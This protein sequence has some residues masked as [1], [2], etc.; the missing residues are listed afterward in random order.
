[1]N[2]SYHFAER[3]KEERKRLKLSQADAA[4][5]V[6]ISREMWGKYERGSKPGAD[7]LSSMERCGFNV[8]YI[9]AGNNTLSLQV[10]T[11]EVEVL[12]K[13]RLASDAIQSAIFALLNMTPDVANNTKDIKNG[14]I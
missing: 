9:L 6:G 1:M 4:A 5:S 14:K 10:T 13:F 7:I 8:A 12:Y 2:N 3:L 11:Q